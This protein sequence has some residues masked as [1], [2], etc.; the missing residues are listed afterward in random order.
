VRLRLL[1]PAA[2]RGQPVVMLASRRRTFQTCRGQSVARHS[3]EV[4]RCPSQT[5]ASHAPEWSS[6]LHVVV[7]QGIC[8]PGVDALSCRP[9]AHTSRIQADAARIIIVSS[10]ST[11]SSAQ[12]H[13]E[14]V[15]RSSSTDSIIGEADTSAQVTAACCPRAHGVGCHWSLKNMPQAEHASYDPVSNRAICVA[16]ASAR[17]HQ[18]PV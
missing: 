18:G 10:T 1:R 2:W 17:A 15:Q 13:G 5:R 16:K 7:A 8:R 6:S 4:L 11:R 14:D 9:R 12:A 3:A